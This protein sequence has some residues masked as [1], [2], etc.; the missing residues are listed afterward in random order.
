MNSSRM[1]CGLFLKEVGRAPILFYGYLKHILFEHLFFQTV[2]I[3]PPKKTFTNCMPR[4]TLNT[5][6]SFSSAYERLFFSVLFLPIESLGK[7]IFLPYKFGELLI[8]PVKNVPLSISRTK[9]MSIG[10]HTYI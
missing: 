8:P 9:G 10:I 5:R 4:Q 3:F 1:L 7:S 6:T 2:S